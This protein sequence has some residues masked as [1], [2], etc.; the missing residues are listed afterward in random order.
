MAEFEPVGTH[1]DY[2][3][4]GLARSVI[5]EGLRRLEKYNPSLIC[6][7][8][9][10]ATEAANKLYDSIGFTYKTRVHLWRKRL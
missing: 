7:Q 2:R 6:I 5:C 1:P 8:G 9:A 10:A 4:L 3:Q